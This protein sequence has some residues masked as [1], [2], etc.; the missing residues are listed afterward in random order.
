VRRAAEG[1]LAPPAVQ[2]LRA[3]V[4]IANPTIGNVTYEDGVVGQLEELG[5]LARGLSA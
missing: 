3:A 4:P 5:L 1:F 2:L